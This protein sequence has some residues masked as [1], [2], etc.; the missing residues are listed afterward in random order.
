[1]EECKERKMKWRSLKAERAMRESEAGGVGIGPRAEVEMKAKWP[2][3]SRVED[4]VLGVLER[5]LLVE[6]GMEP[7]RYGRSSLLS[8]GSELHQVG[9]GGCLVDRSCTA[10]L[11]SAT[12]TTLIIPPGYGVVTVC[13]CSSYIVLRTAAQHTLLYNHLDA[14]CA[15]E[16]RNIKSTPCS[17]VHPYSIPVS[18]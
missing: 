3:K 11:P 6:T 8:D 7:G 12:T 5:R 18:A 14:R 4:G 2:V 16:D 17:T 1:M 9:R 10:S 13:T 15:E